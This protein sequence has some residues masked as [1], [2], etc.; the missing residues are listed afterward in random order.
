MKINFV[1]GKIVGNPTDT[2]NVE[3]RIK[4]YL[5]DEKAFTVPKD[6]IVKVSVY[7]DDPPFFKIMGEI[8][9]SAN[10]RLLRFSFP[11]GEKI[12]VTE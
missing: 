6:G 8:C 2:D 7:S 5:S 3:A 9:D 1:W 10:Q 4:E 11:D 12:V